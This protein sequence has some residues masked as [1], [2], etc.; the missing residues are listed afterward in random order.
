MAY[1][2]NNARDVAW[3]SSKAFIWDA[4]RINLPSGRKALAMS[5]YPEESKGD[6]AWGRATEY[7]KGSI[8]NYSFRII[9]S[10]FSNILLILL[11]T[12]HSM[13]VALNILVFCFFGI[14]LKH[15]ACLV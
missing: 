9:Q 11:P 2:I 12:L 4:A 13:F 6:N 1:K 5:A 7:A 3:A 10:D 15:Q 8:E 14:L